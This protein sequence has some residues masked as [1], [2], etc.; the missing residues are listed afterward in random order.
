MIE[1]LALEVD[2]STPAVLLAE[3]HRLGERTRPPGVGVME[4]IEFSVEV[5][6]RHGFGESGLESIECRGESLRHEATAVGAEVP[7][8]HLGATRLGATRLG[9]TRLRASHVCL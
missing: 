2:P 5:R 8:C 4:A 1:V 9:A 6:V 3:A 7:R